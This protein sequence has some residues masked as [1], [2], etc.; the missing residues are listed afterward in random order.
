MPEN[1]ESL[2]S[3]AHIVLRP[4]S[5][6]IV[7]L[8]PQELGPALVVLAAEPPVFASV[9]AEPDVTTL[10]VPALVWERMADDFSVARVESGYRVITFDLEMGWEIVGFMAC[11]TGLL[12]AAEIPLGAICGYTRDH[13]F[14]QEQYA[15]RA[16]AI[17][18]RGSGR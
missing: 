10:V 12:A 6:V 7:G 8:S 3:R 2:L 11:A 18:K 9:V 16:V 17:L 1:A 14:V 13:L 4:E 15:D 5:Y